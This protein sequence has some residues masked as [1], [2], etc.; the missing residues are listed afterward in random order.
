MLT[1]RKLRGVINLLSDPLQAGAA[2]N[3]LAQEAQRRRMLVPDL[4]AE[5]AGLASM[6]MSVESAAPEAPT[7]W[8]EAG[9]DGAY[10]KRVDDR[11]ISLVGPV[12]HETE[13][14]WR[15]K[16][17]DGGLAWLAKSQCGHHGEDDRGRTI[18]LVPRWL[19]DRIGLRATP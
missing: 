9:E 10:A 6:S 18:L 16:T 13:K 15:I 4:I 11:R 19:A 7:P 14:A 1:A 8:R 5:V 2:V 17:P 3:I 12:V